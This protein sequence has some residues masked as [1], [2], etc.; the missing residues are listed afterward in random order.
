[1]TNENI[2]NILGALITADEFGDDLLKLNGKPK[3]ESFGISTS[4]YHSPT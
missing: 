2:L 3:N 1:M 4:Y